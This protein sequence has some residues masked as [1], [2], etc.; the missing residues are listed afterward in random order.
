M[1]IQTINNKHYQECDI[2]MLP[3][4]NLVGKQDL[5]LIGNWK[6][7]HLMTNWQPKLAEDEKAQHLNILSNEKIKEGDFQI[8]ID[9]N[10]PHY[11]Q[12]SNKTNNAVNSGAYK[13]IIATTDSSLFVNTNCE[14]YK[15]EHCGGYCCGVK[16]IS[17]QFIEYFI[18]EYNKGNV[19]SKV[20]IE[21]EE[22]TDIEVKYKYPFGD[23][24]K[25]VGTGTYKIKLNQN[26]E[27]SIL[28]QHEISE[29]AKERSIRYMKLKAGV[30]KTIKHLKELNEELKKINKE[31][32]DK[33]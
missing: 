19:I 11:N 8:C 10:N 4:D 20:L 21:V 9:P 17:Q 24:A 18:S 23:I 32:N 26:N 29:I 12:I 27:I 2:I 33:K 13:K 16:Q 30:E 14:T 28:T 22:K 5:I 3:T 1:K 31:L 15:K 7:L 25:E 6:K